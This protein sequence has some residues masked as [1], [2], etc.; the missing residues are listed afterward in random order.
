MEKPSF[1]GRSVAYRAAFEKELDA[2]SEEKLKQ[3][4]YLQQIF[5]GVRCADLSYFTSQ[6][7]EIFYDMQNELIEMV[8]PRVRG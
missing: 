3:V 4:E 7:L 2:A 6:A 5:W 1:S 8:R